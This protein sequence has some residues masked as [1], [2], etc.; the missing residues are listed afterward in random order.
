MTTLR[1]VSTSPSETPGTDAD[2]ALGVLIGDPSWLTS[3]APSAELGVLRDLACALVDLA[4]GAR[5]SALVLT[6]AKPTLRGAPWQVGLERD[7]ESLLVSV[8]RH[9]AVPDVAQ[10]ERRIP[11]R[12]ARAALLEAI[13]RTEMDRGLGLAR[14]ELAA[15]RIRRVA[16]RSSRRIS[17]DSGPGCV[18]I[19]ANAS[20]RL[21]ASSPSDVARADLQALFH[22]GK[23]TA[24]NANARCRLD[25]V[26]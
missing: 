18:R 7:G 25:G 13:E 4:R 12:E 9:G 2:R 26:L 23:L 16:A 17:A 6:P 1:L 10:A 5:D 19:R 14:D 20:A 21:R 15:T 11:L 24:Q 8:F 3:L 22:R